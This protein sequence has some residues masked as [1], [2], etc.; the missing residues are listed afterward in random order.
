M[1]HRNYERGKR[2]V[3]SKTDGDALLTMSRVAF[4]GPTQLLSADQK[5]EIVNREVDNTR[6]E[7]GKTQRQGERLLDDLEVQAFVWT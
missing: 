2:K 5:L 7:I 3:W 1:S 4:K 6:V